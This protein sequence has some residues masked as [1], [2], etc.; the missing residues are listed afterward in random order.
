MKVNVSAIIIHKNKALII[1]RSLDNKYFPGLWAVAGGGMEDEDGSIQDVA[2]REAR[3]EVGVDIVPQDLVHNNYDSEN[4]VLFF[5][6][7]ASLR[8][9]EDFKRNLTISDELNDYKWAELK[10]L[11]DLE[12]TPFTKKEIERLLLERGL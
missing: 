2:I 6:F 12:F 5:K 9:E 4:D 11:A 3:E 10:D 7:V 8:N 1:Q